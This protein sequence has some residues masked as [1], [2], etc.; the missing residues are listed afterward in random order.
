MTA[1]NRA[2]ELLN[3]LGLR[4][5]VLDQ[6]TQI[7]SKSNSVVYQEPREGF[8]RGIDIYSPDALLEVMTRDF[9]IFKDKFGKIPDLFAPKFFSE[10]L[11]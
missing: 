7:W 4:K 6:I 11:I 9:K 3:G 10:K 2:K 1:E 8:L 5:H